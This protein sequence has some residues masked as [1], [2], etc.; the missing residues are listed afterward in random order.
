M[1]KPAPIRIISGSLDGVGEDLLSRLD[2]LELGVVLDFLARIAIWMVLERY[3]RKS[4]RVQALGQATR[5][6]RTKLL[7]LS[8]DLVDIR[9]GR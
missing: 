4:V 9:P 5:G 7:V 8:V 3:K 1:T 6:R 2:A